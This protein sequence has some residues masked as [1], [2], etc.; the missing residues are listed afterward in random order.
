MEP[1]NHADYQITKNCL[2][3][4]V[5]Q[6]E[7]AGFLKSCALHT[8][9]VVVTF[10]SSAS[11]AV[12]QIATV[13]LKVVPAV[14]LSLG[15]GL[16]RVARENDFEL[17]EKYGIT[18]VGKHAFQAVKYTVGIV[19]I[20][21]LTLISPKLAQDWYVGKPDEPTPSPTSTPGTSATET[22]TDTAKNDGPATDTAT[23]VPAPPAPKADGPPMKRGTPPPLPPPG[24]GPKIKPQPK[25]EAQPQPEAK[26][27]DAGQKPAKP[28]Q[29]SE[30]FEGF[31]EAIA[32]RRAKNQE[33]EE[34]AEK[35]DKERQE[36]AYAALNAAKNPAP[37]NPAPANPPPARPI[38][39]IPVQA[40][41]VPPP[42]V[43]PVATAATPR[44]QP[45]TPRN[46]GAT[47]GTPRPG[48]S[49]PSV[50]LNEMAKVRAEMAAKKA[51]REAEAAAS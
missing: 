1:Y 20:P 51:K 13:I 48:A 38:P 3:W 30:R 35:A 26:P 16:A 50:D 40:G 36:R 31:A 29:S 15:N 2:D 41:Q 22:A 21:V 45:P 27:A 34:L 17:I 49:Q 33:A 28:N 32:K 25:P 23:N 8:S 46:G 14:F 47:A 19:V 5:K 42:P 18:A 39:N 43:K 10:F 37:S 4:F 9:G 44:Q 11:E 12:A 6:D 7:T 24:S